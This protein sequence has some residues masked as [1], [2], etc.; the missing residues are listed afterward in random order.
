LSDV[1]IRVLGSLRSL[2]GGSA[3]L[4]VFGLDDDSTDQECDRTSSALGDRPGTNVR[5]F[6]GDHNGI[7]DNPEAFAA[8]LAQCS[9]TGPARDTAR[10]FRSRIRLWDAAGSVQ[11]ENSRI[12]PALPPPVGKQASQFLLTL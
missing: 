12:W 6:P 10:P 3:T 1:D 2:R 8:R 11:G 9:K 4:I 5:S 7:V